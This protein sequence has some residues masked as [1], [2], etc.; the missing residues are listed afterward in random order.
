M[1]DRVCNNPQVSNFNWDHLRAFLSVARSGRLVAAA[2][3]LKTDHT[4]VARRIT[5]L[6][7]S[8]NATLFTRSPQGYELT[9]QGSSILTM[10][11]GMEA[12]ALQTIDQVS[13]DDL[14]VSGTVRIAA[15]EGFGSYFLAPRF[16][17]L[18]EKHPDLNV[19]LIASPNLVSLSKRE[20]DLAIVLSRPEGGRLVA[21]KLT[22][23]EL[24]LFA[25]RDYVDNS[26]PIKTERDLSNHR[27]VGYID[28]LLY[29]PELD[30]AHDVHAGVKTA[31]GSNNLV[32]QLAAT[33]R[34]AGLCILPNFIASQYETLRQVLPNQV[35]LTREFWLIGHADS[36][37]IRRIQTVNAYISEC[38]RAEKGLFALPNS[39]GTKQA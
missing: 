15:P 13:G 26:A 38:V 33:L 22:D 30:Y 19:E 39:A 21:K 20:A 35:R 8:L 24:G 1:A 23:F 4:T 14:S 18:L 6:E 34:D 2:K 9:E 32:A 28:D 31:L 17:G 11:E 29:A 27:F 25:S 7:Q 12:L 3:Q 5:A 10:V 37:N 16:T 36:R